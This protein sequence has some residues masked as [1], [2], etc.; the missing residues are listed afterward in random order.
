MVL[1]SAA[2]A[3]LAVSVRAAVSPTTGKPPIPRPDIR[4]WPLSPSRAHAASAARDPA[5]VCFVAPGAAG[6]DDAPAILGAFRDCNNGGTV[7]LDANYTIGSPLDL[8]FLRSVDVAL[9][10]TVA[11]SDNVAAWR[12]R[13]FKIAYQNSSAMWKVGG[14]DVNIYGGGVGLLDGRGQ[15]WWDA[16]AADSTLLRPI[17][18]VVDGLHGGSVTGLKMR[19]SPM[20]FN[21]IANSSDVVVSDISIG[22]KSTSRNKPGNTDGWDTYRSTGIVIQH[23]HIQNGDDCV[24]FK[25]NSTD[26]VIQGRTQ[27]PLFRARQKLTHDAVVVCEGS[28][29]ISVG[30]LGQYPD[31]FD[32][33]ENVYVA[34]ITMS[35]AS[36]GARIK[37]WPGTQ[38]SFQPNLNGGGGRGYVRNVT[39]DG[40]VNRN[41]DWAVELTQCYGQKSQEV[42]NR[43]P[44]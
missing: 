7:V 32:I 26:V 16:A 17:L 21:L 33:V 18:L 34:N 2:L 28:H 24:S 11:F 39:F 4:A 13:T 36:D 20:W 10:G 12:P 6:G 30:S 27:A 8:T 35:D 38:T 25:P 40:F 29:G 3:L 23:S 9:S 19:N 44:V 42:C 43:F 37:V 5:K 41:N 22:V 15:A 14:A 31:E 1:R